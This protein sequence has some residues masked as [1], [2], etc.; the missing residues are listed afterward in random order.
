MKTTVDIDDAL[1]RAVEDQARKQGKPLGILIEEALRVTVKAANN[2]ASAADE[3]STGEG[4]EE[5]DPFF[6]ALE[7]IRALGRLSAPHR[8]VLFP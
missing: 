6:A 3:S 5:N 2:F 8:E 7:E 4:L 1:L